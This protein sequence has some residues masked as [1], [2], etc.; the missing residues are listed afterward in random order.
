MF[1]LDND[2]GLTDLL[3]GDGVSLASAIRPT[4]QKNLDILTA[5]RHPPNPAELLGSQRMRSFLPSL[6]EGYDLVVFD[7]P[8][9]DVFTDSAVLSSFLDGSIMVIEVRRGRR[10]QIRAAREALGKANAHVIGAVLNGLPPKAASEYGRYYGTSAEAATGVQIAPAGSRDGAS[11]IQ[12][13]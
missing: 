1:A 7:G 12:P 13:R 4:E 3:R 10:A 5:G 6:A 8:P 9:L 2:L 11:D